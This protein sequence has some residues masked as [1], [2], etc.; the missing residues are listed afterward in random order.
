MGQLTRSFG[1][2]EMAPDYACAVLVT[3]GSEVST[4]D[5]T[6]NSSSKVLTEAAVEFTTDESVKNA[7]RRLAYWKGREG[8]AAF[9][10]RQ[11]IMGMTY[12]Q[13]NLLTMMHLDAVMQPAS[14]FMHDWMHGLF[15]NGVFNLVFHLLLCTLEKHGGMQQLYPMLEE[16]VS[17]WNWPGRVGHKPCGTMFDSVRK[18]QIQM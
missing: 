11:Q 13:H 7:A 14:Q 5:P 4:I 9:T 3:D 6:I 16:Y 1:H 15:S 17:H 10:R 18:E 2:A 12:M 8:T